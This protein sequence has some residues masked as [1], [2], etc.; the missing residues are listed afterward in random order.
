MNRQAAAR[1]LRLR[2][3]VPAARLLRRAFGGPRWRHVVNVASVPHLTID[4]QALLLGIRPYVAGSPRPHRVWEAGLHFAWL[5]SNACFPVAR[6]TGALPW[7]LRSRSRWR[8][9]NLTR[10]GDDRAT[11]R[12][13]LGF[14][15]TAIELADRHRVELY[16]DVLRD[17]DR[18]I[19]AYRRHGFTTFEE[20]GDLV[21]MRRGPATAD[22]T[23]RAAA[24]G[25]L[26]TGRSTLVAVER[27]YGTI[28]GP[29][30]DVGAGDSPLVAQ[31]SGGGLL[32]V[33]L[34]PQYAARPP[35]PARGRYVTGVVEELP[36]ADGT[37]AVVHC[38]HSLQ[39]VRL[40]ASALLEC[41]RVTAADGRVIIHPVWGPARWRRRL[42]ALP[43][44]RLLP[45]RVLPPRRQRPSLVLHRAAFLPGEALPLVAAVVRPGWPARAAGRLAMRILVRTRGTTSI[46]PG[47][48]R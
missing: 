26:R 41:L 9:V 47:A 33:G 21:R 32:A 34:D 46:G 36:F 7:G 14:A 10:G 3:L 48:A 28:G 15:L 16:L 6:R 29:L 44:V 31:A 5:L 13:V 40:P 23:R 2:D 19:R 39:H 17:R 43:G 27:R 18:L 45:G 30:L 42:V 38:S 11:S 35:A 12:F 24:S 22:A 25:V 37:F 1:W 20:A 4:G 8:I